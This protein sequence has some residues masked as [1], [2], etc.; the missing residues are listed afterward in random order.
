MRAYVNMTSAH[1]GYISL[2][3]Y[4]S[5]QVTCLVLVNTLTSKSEPSARFFPK[6]L[7]TFGFTLANRRSFS[8]KLTSQLTNQPKHAGP[9]PH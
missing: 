2:F 8:R 7:S 3:P 1:P 4:H 9:V 6:H 5:S